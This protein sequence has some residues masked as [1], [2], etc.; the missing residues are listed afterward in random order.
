MKRDTIF[1]HKVQYDTETRIEK[2]RTQKRGLKNSYIITS[3]VW[4]NFW[5]TSAWC[6]DR[7]GL[8]INFW[9]M[10]IIFHTP[11][12]YAISHTITSQTMLIGDVAGHQHISLFWQ[13]RSFARVGCLKLHQKPIGA[14]NGQQHRNDVRPT[15]AV[16]TC[17]WER[18]RCFFW[19]MAL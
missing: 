19:K 12:Q 7:G 18:K 4:A 14:I 17:V 9:I 15:W 16:P 2:P 8:D 6:I 1:E 10:Y 5:V 3:L 13:S 11:T